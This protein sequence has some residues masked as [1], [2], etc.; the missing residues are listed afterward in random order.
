MSRLV[1][2]CTNLG[3]GNIALL[4]VLHGAL[5]SPPDG[6]GRDT[7]SFAAECTREAIHGG[8]RVLKKTRVMWISRGIYRGKYVRCVDAR[9]GIYCPLC[10]RGVEQSTCFPQSLGLV[11]DPMNSCLSQALHFTH[12]R[13]CD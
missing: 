8:F 10:L 13:S 2:Q 7:S 1:A 6:T 4:I 12:K 5:H 3:G 9:A 11:V